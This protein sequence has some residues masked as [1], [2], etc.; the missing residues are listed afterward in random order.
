MP[1]RSRS[2]AEKEPL[3][4]SAPD[5]PYTPSSTRLRP[6]DQAEV[7]K[8][9]ESAIARAQS[10]RGVTPHGER[11]KLQ[12]SKKGVIQ[13]VWEHLFG[14]TRVVYNPEMTAKLTDA[15]GMFLVVVFA[16]YFTAFGYLW[17]R[18]TALGIQ[19]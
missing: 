10:A 7:Q 8:L 1:P 13:R 6:P 19:R 9:V 3:P 15:A 16:F 18:E 4:T 12:E 5:T 17:Y 14:N 11:N 2:K